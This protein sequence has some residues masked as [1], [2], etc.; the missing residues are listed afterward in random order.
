MVLAIYMTVPE[1]KLKLET[2]FYHTDRIMWHK[3]EVNN[4]HMAG[5]EILIRSFMKSFGLFATES[6]HKN[7][8]L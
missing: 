2:K 5:A 1:M 8:I 3:Q 7:K 4:R 6:I